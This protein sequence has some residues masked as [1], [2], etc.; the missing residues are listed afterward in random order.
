KTEVALR[1]MF[2]AVMSGKQA[3]LL[4][5][6]TILAEQHFQTLQSRLVN[7]EAVRVESISRFKTSKEQKKILADLADGKIDMIVGTHRLLGKDVRFKR[8]GLLVVDEEQR[9]GVRHK[10]R[11]KELK[12]NIDVLTMS[13][14]P[15]PRTLNMA[16]SGIR[17]MS[18]LETPPQERYPVQTYVLEYAD[19][20]V[21]DAVL[22]EIDRG[23][24]VFYLFNRVQGID[25]FAEH[26]RTLVPQARIAVAHGQMDEKLLEEVVLDFYNGAYDVLLCTTI[27][28]N[29][30]DI[31]GANT[32]IVQDAHRLG[33]AQ[34]YQLRGRVG[35][36]NRL[37]YAYFTVPPLHSLSEDAVKRLKTIE[38]F[39]QMGSGFKIA[40]RD[41]EI[42]GAGD[43]LGGEQHGHMSRIGYDLYCKMV[44]E[45]VDEGLGRKKEETPFAAVEVKINAYLDDDWISSEAVRFA[46]Y[47]RISE[48]TDRDDVTEM[49]EE[50]TDRFGPVPPAADALLSVAYL[51]ALGGR[52]GVSVIRQEKD[53]FV[54]FFPK[55][56][57]KRI[58]R[59]VSAMPEDC[60]V[61]AGSVFSIAL[62]TAGKTDAE[63]LALAICFLERIEQAPDIS[64][65]T[66]NF[67]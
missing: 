12:T 30:V 24:Q 66:A 49:R 34:L 2:K 17:D 63:K 62:K 35:R 11:I 54:L 38:E 51:R 8:L 21:R 3:A 10:E 32:I 64:P 58:L 29:G 56:D 47:R 4:A 20:I 15:I 25:L 1:A 57:L 16:L 19:T 67:S 40:L 14:T 53:D 65:N 52:A 31:P 6:T 50:L 59:A 13:A 5:P 28:E 48:L 46:T 26:L 37:A 60:R 39:T 61:S 45:S 9:F 7:F 44:R 36:S 18:L 42:R 43:L 23:G 27:I 55:P 33:L 22:R 41:L